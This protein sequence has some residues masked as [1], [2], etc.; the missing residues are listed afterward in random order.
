MI[1]STVDFYDFIHRC[2]EGL[3]GF[4]EVIVPSKP[5]IDNN[6]N[7]FWKKHKPGEEVKLFSYRTVDPLKYFFIRQRESISVES[8]I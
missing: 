6:G 5:N 7:T 2:T 1:V 3:G 8:K 4:T